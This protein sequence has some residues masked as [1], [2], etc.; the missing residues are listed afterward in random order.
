MLCELARFESGERQLGL[1]L[2]ET[3]DNS[4]LGILLALLTQHL[5]RVNFTCD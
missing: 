3:A 5:S 2:Q 1:H 4:A